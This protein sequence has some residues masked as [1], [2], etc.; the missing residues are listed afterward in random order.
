M[1]LYAEW[2]GDPALPRENWIARPPGTIFRFGVL[3]LTV[4][5]HFPEMTL[6]YDALFSRRAC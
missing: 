5:A 3:L 6:D 4:Q 1:G 2:C